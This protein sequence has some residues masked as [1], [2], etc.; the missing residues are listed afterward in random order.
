MNIPSVGGKDIWLGQAVAGTG[1]LTVQGGTRALT[2]AAAQ[3]LQRRGK[4]RP[5]PDHRVIIF[6]AT[7]LGTGTFRSERTVAGS[8]MLET[9]AD[10]SSGPGW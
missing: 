10:L 7:S 8:G 3:Y 6:N 1:G 9:A 2:L 5:M 4:A